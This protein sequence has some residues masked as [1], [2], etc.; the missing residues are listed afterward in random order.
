MCDNIKFEDALQ[1]LEEIVRQMENGTL[2]LDESITK[3]K[4]AVELVK[5]CNSKLEEA[6]QVVKILAESHDGTV[7]DRDFVNNES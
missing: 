1:K 5:L 3:Y 4:E 7:Y 2:T 6:D